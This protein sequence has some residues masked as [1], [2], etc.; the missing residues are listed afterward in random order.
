VARPTKRF[1]YQPRDPNVVKIRS[2]QRS[3]D[4]DSIYKERVKIF[5]PRE[6]KN[7]IRILP[8]S[9]PQADHYGYEIFVNYGIGVDDNAYLSLSAMKNEADPLAEARKQAEREGDKKLADSLKP[10]KRVLFYLIDRMAEEEGVQLWAA[11]WTVDKCFCGIAIDEDT[12]SVTMVDHPE[13]GYDIVFTKEGTGLTT[14]Y[15]AEKMRIK[16]APSPLHEDENLANEWLGYIQENPL[17]DQLNFY[18]Y[19]HIANAFEGHVAK[20]T[21]ERLSKRT[22]TKDDDDNEPTAKPSKTKPKPVVD[23]DEDV[24]EDTGEV[25]KKP[26]GGKVAAKKPEPEDDEAET[27]KMSVSSIRERLAGRRGRPAVEDDD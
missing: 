1:P 16:K 24:D 18:P 27:A 25:T 22:T 20:S 15:P 23:D 19:E 17:P 6:G 10:N 2:N 9:W 11:P 21:D 3:G 14:K 8:P 7:T 13:D 26:N 5:K 12:G 4:F